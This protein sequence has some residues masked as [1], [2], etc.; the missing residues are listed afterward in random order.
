MLSRKRVKKALIMQ[1][2]CSC[3]SASL[4]FACNKVRFYHNTAHISLDRW[5]SKTLIQLTKVDQKLL[6]TVCLVAICRQS[7]D[8]LQSKTLFLTI[9]DLHSL[10]VLTFLIATYPV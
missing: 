4:M 6:E 2:A 1:R 10:I 7:G 9:F 3:W 8:K 5:Q